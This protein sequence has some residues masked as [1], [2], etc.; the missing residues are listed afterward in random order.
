MEV[1]LNKQN[2]YGK[3]FGNEV[4]RFA[5]PKDGTYRVSASSVFTQSAVG[6]YPKMNGN[7]SMRIQIASKAITYIGTDGMY[8]HSG[9]NKCLYVNEKST[10]I[11]HGFNGVKWDNTDAGGNRTMKV[12]TGITGASPNL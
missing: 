10:V 5:V 12:V 7:L 1:T 4:V 8:C 9:A 6:N 3:Y 11:Q 2:D